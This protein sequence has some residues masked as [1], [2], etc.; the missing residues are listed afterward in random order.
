M[1]TFLGYVMIA[2]L[3]AGLYATVMFGPLYV[4]QM[5]VKDICNSAFNRFKD[6]GAEGLKADVL[7]RLNGVDWA[8]HEERDPET[9]QVVVKPGLG[10]TEE[11]V[12]VEVDERA[13]KVFLRVDYQ[14]KVVLK[15]TEKVRVVKFHFERRDTPPNASF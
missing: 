11:D 7:T 12:L 9:D 15:P 4:D 14:R 5:H 2:G 8:T 3:L 6:V 10:L 13:K 1:R